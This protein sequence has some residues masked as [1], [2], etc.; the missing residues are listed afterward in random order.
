M[1]ARS[2]R[3]NSKTLQQ[4]T[5]SSFQPNIPAQMW[6][7]QFGG[8]PFWSLWSMKY[9]LCRIACVA[10]SSKFSLK[11][12]VMFQKIQFI[13][14]L[15]P[16]IKVYLLQCINYYTV[17]LSKPHYVIKL[18]HTSVTNKVIKLWWSAGV[19]HFHIGWIFLMNFFEN[20]LLSGAVWSKMSVL[21][22]V[23]QRLLKRAENRVI[24][25][26]QQK[27]RLLSGDE[28]S[29]IYHLPVAL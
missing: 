18:I 22:I 13:P 8:D 20:M 9:A 28:N 25:I 4:I 27:L 21:F 1:K 16:L 6:A 14:I 5:C 15:G 7:L 11:A 26:F 29:A 19:Q 23:K 12:D 10:I 2:E 17:Q 24:I 3:C